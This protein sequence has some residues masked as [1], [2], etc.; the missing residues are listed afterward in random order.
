MPR[1]VPSGGSRRLKPPRTRPRVLAH[2]CFC[3]KPHPQRNPIAAHRRSKSPIT[4]KRCGRN[5]LTKGSGNTAR[6]TN[7]PAKNTPP[8]P[9]RRMA[10]ITIQKMARR[11][12]W[13]ATRPRGAGT[14]GVAALGFPQLGQ[15]FWPACMLPPQ[16]LQNMAPDPLL[17]GQRQKGSGIILGK[18]TF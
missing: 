11:L 1:I 2:E 4:G 17:R 10:E 9:T 6:L 14:A 3:S 12:R 7:L 13:R 8:E 18:Q 15:K 16:W 5:W